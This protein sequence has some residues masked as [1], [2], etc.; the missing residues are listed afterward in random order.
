VPRTATAAASRAS[1]ASARPAVVGRSGVG[2]HA[3]TA[4]S[5]RLTLQYQEV[6]N[7]YELCL[8]RLAEAAELRRR[9]AELRAANGA[10]SR[11]SATLASR[12][13][14]QQSPT[15]SDSS[16]LASCACPRRG[17][18]RAAQTARA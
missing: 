15:R 7:L 3:A 1:A 4:S 17:P 5:S 14:P 2:V 10:A 16:A 8:A 6:A 18:A 12:P 9:N 11:C 13:P